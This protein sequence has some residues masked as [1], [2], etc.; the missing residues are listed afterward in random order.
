ML[1]NE[2]LGAAI[3]HA[4]KRIDKFKYRA[5]FR[6]PASADRELEE[7]LE[8]VKLTSLSAGMAKAQDP[9]EECTTPGAP[10]TANERTL[11]N[12]VLPHKDLV[13][14]NFRDELQNAFVNLR[15]EDGS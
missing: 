5:G 4:T 2:K 15:G 8:T 6:D 10:G 9:E 11:C 12:L 13:G 3:I 7:F 1:E 14:L